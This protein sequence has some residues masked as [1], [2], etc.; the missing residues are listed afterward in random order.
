MLK[1]S[2]NQSPPNLGYYCTRMLSHITGSKMCRLFLY[3]VFGQSSIIFGSTSSKALGSGFAFRS[4]WSEMSASFMVI[5]NS[6]TNEA[7]AQ[8][9]CV[10][11]TAGCR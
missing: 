10:T 1:L 2:T 11:V 8:L 9:A 7:V 4:L 6:T 5:I 3:C